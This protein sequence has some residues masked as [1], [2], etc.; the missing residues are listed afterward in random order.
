MRDR[1]H[2]DNCFAVLRRAG[3]H[4]RAGPDF[5][6]FFASLPV[7]GMPEIGVADDK[8]GLWDGKRHASRLVQLLVEMPVMRGHFRPG[9][10]FEIGVAQFARQQD[11]APVK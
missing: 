3:Q 10:G 9:D 6:T 8:A 11:F 7:L 4:N 5:Q 1:N 2:R